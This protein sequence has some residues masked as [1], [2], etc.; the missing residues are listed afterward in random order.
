MPAGI[1]VHE[2]PLFVPSDYAVDGCRKTVERFCWSRSLSKLR[3]RR[4]TCIHTVLDYLVQGN[5]GETPLQPQRLQS[6]IQAH[7]EQ[8]VKAYGEEPVT[9]KF[10]MTMHLPMMLKRSGDSRTL[11]GFFQMR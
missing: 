3:V 5:R 6:V 4:A 7:C 2:G 10:H 8:F 9:P 1:W 11:A